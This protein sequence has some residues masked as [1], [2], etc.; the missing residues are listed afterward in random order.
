MW[1]YQWALLYV[2]YEIGPSKKIPILEIT[3][4]WEGVNSKIHFLPEPVAG[5]SWWV[6]YSAGE[7]SSRKKS[8]GKHSAYPRQKRW[9]NSGNCFHE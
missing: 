8:F 5:N 6:L 3:L 9:V 7:L 2:L 4:C 1:L